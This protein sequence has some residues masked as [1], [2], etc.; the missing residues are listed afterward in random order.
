[1]FFT[2]CGFF[3]FLVGILVIL[4]TSFILGI[5]DFQQTSS[6]HLVNIFHL[7]IFFLVPGNYLF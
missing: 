3:F 6:Q 7:K 2:L 5:S 4:S 1:M